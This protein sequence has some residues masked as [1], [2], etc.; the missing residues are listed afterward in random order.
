MKEDSL[1][2]TVNVEGLSITLAPSVLHGSLRGV[3]GSDGVEPSGVGD[4]GR[5]SGQNEAESGTREVGVQPIHRCSNASEWDIAAGDGG[6]LP[7]DIP[8]DLQRGG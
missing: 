5:I 4:E 3:T 2:D 6:V 7:N 8:V 1:P